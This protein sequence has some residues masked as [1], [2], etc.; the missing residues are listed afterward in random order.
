MWSRSPSLAITEHSHQI[1]ACGVDCGRSSPSVSLLER[2]PRQRG[3]GPEGERP[4]GPDRRVWQSLSTHI[5]SERAV[6][7]V[8]AAHQVCPYSNATRGNVEVDLKANGHVVPIAES[9]NH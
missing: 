8:A 6:S 7:I 3:S 5:R 9:G 4:C 1:G 2:H